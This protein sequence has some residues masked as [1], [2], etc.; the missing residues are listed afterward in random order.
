MTETL[1]GSLKVERLHGMRF[2][3]RRQAKDEVMDWITL[4]SQP[5]AAAFDAG[6]YQPDG[7]RAEMACRLGSIVS[8]S[9]ETLNEGKVPQAKHF[10]VHISILRTSYAGDG[11]YTH[12]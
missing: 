10:A 3:T 6:L 12:L 1:F 9:R 4:P 2:G 8:T 5:S 11:Y 7:F